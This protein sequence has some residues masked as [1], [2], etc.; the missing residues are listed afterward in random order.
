MSHP[1]IVS[2]REM[3]MLYIVLPR[4]VCD[5]ATLLIRF[6]NQRDIITGVEHGTQHSNKAQMTLTR[7]VVYCS[8][9]VL[10]HSAV[11]VNECPLFAG[12]H[13]GPWFIARSSKSIPNDS[14]VHQPL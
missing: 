14:I 7:L 9:Y 5:R 11:V 3:A 10:V 6:S 1:R 2:R 13:L 4:H 12:Q 8:V